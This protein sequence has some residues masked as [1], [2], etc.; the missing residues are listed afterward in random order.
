MTRRNRVDPWGDLHAD[1]ARGMFTGNR[2]CL[3]DGAGALVRHHRGNLWITCVTRFRD[4]RVGL[5]RPG[6]WTP[7]FFLDDAV[8]L[9]AGHRPC[10][11]CRHAAYL[12]YREAVAASLGAPVRAGDLNRALA[13]ERLRPGRGLDR[14]RDRRTWRGTDVPDGTVVVTDGPRLVLGDRLLAFSPGGW[15]D[16]ALRP[17]GE[18]TV[19]TP[20]TSVAALRHGFAPELDQ[21]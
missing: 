8:A 5:A 18:L 21:R 7:V 20:P 19:L 14:A 9:A 6:R 11:E 4:R 16:P 17:A 2:G 12:A 13:A 3:V 15:R 10:G 1:P